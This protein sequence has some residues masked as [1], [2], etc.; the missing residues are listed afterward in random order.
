LQNALQPLKPNG[1]AG[2]EIGSFRPPNE[3]TQ[4]HAARATQQMRGQRA[5]RQRPTDALHATQQKK[6][7]HI[8][9]NIAIAAAAIRIP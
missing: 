3:S 1:P 2:D 7:K 8:P 6:T 9:M 4:Y 5:G